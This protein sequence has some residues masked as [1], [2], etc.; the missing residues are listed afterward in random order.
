M[1]INNGS[2]SDLIWCQV[3]LLSSFILFVL[4][5]WILLKA[6]AFIYRND[7]TP[8]IVTL[9]I[10]R[11]DFGKGNEIFKYD[12]AVVFKNNSVEMMF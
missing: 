9:G 10:L 3:S 5:I 2:M 4:C 11:K 8:I 1:A 7:N 6:T 12:D